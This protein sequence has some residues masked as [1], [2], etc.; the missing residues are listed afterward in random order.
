VFSLGATRLLGL[1][2]LCLHT[3]YGAN[4]R[5]QAVNVNDSY[6]CNYISFAFS[7]LRSVV[8]DYRGK[9]FSSIPPL[10]SDR[11]FLDEKWQ[12]A[13]AHSATGVG[14]LALHFGGGRESSVWCLTAIPRCY[15]GAPPCSSPSLA[16]IQTF[17]LAGVMEMQPAYACSLCGR[18]AGQRCTGCRTAMYC[19][20]ECQVRIA[21]ERGQ[22]ARWR[23]QS[24]SCT[25]PPP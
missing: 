17:V 16:P 20:R 1:N 9:S 19:S 15:A 18:P 5:M 24:T 6:T 12:E 3:R 21:W 4:P 7:S 11:E 2:P 23:V 25:Q 13:C 22:T 8:M 14:P 10:L